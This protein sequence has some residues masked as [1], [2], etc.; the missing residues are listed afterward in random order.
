MFY[1]K[2]IIFCSLSVALAFTPGSDKEPGFN[3]TRWWTE[4]VN[5]SD[6]LA[7]IRIPLKF[8]SSPLTQHIPINEDYA[9]DGYI[10]KTSTR[11]LAQTFAAFF[12]SPRSWKSNSY[13]HFSNQQRL[14]NYLRDIGNLEVTLQKFWPRE[15]VS[16]ELGWLKCILTFTTGYILEDLILS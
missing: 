7:E 10:P 2:I 8:E 3:V 9:E 5:D 1:C 12:M 14:K 6:E 13:R 16:I 11:H 4:N 15:I